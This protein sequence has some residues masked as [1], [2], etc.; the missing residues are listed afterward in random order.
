MRRYSSIL[1]VILSLLFSY[2]ADACFILFLK[3]ENNILVANHEDWF[4]N[5]AAIKINPPIQGRYGSVIFTFLTEGWAQGGMNEKGLFF[6]AAQT[7]YQDISFGRDKITPKNY[8]WQEILDKAATVKEALE[9]LNR[10]ALPELSETTVMLADA[11]GDAAIIG[12]HNNEVDIRPVDGRYLIQTN[13]NLW[14]PDLNNEPKCERYQK[15]EQIMSGR[16]DVNV[17]TMRK[18]LEQTHQDSLTVYSN[19]YDL[20]NRTIYTYNK[21]NFSDAIITN[22]PDIFKHGDCLFS[23]DSLSRNHS[24][25]DNCQPSGEKFFT[26]KGKVT[27][28]KGMPLPY[29]NIGLYEKNVG[30]LSDPDGTFEI[31][32]PAASSNDSLIFS[33]IG[34]ETKKIA[35]SGLGLSKFHHNIRLTPAAILLD[36]VTISDKKLKSKIMRL[37]W[38]GG[39]DGIL[40]LDT[41]MGGGAVALLVEAPRA[42]FYIEKLQLRLMYNSKD[43]IKFRFHIY[44]FDSINRKPGKDLL[45]REIILTEQKKF[46]WLRFDLSRENITVNR[47]KICIGFEWIDVRQYRM[48]MIN[49][50]RQWELWKKEQF[51]LG[52]KKVEY[53]SPK[54][55][56]VGGYYKY[57]GNMMDWP[58]FKMLP[59]FTG[60]MVETG[61]HSETEKLIT[62]ERKTSFGQWTENPS[63]LN[64]VITI[65]Y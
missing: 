57:H 39:K 62:F 2:S 15:A 60:L 56:D 52:N 58:G 8:P 43:T 26:V 55:G 21:R 29:A 1:L 31:T 45:N 37:G 54:D 49:G 6:D 30:T 63:T 12:V 35:V 28:E 25:V 18:I 7:P 17:T 14:H 5:D 34:Y 48:G 16:P 23:L 22:I 41:V 33:T 53:I 10:Y 59:P 47:K 3:D 11:T 20:K 38:M 24:Y 42:P 32:L 4:A 64:A 44:E 13:F 51:A 46:G 40:P 61:K 65:V 36:E 27:D 9:I 50:L 19:V